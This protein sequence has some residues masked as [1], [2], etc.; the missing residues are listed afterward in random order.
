MLRS[1][2]MRH[3]A[4]WI[5]ALV[6]TLVTCSDGLS[7]KDERT[8][9]RAMKTVEQA[10]ERVRT[11]VLRTCDKWMHQRRACEDN[12]ARVAQMECWIEMG[13][14]HLKGALRRNLRQR[15]RDKKIMLHQNI[16][17]ENR[18]WRFRKPNKEDF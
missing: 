13:L 16:C 12:D 1:E 14:P 2:P 11:E 5:P 7:P 9:K 17:M 8:I 4:W 6:L 3:A 10:P 18:G 15:T